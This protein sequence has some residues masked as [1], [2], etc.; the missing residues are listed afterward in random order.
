MRIHILEEGD[1][2]MKRVLTASLA[3]VLMMASLLLPSC[4]KSVFTMS[5]NT[6][7][8]MTIEAKNADKDAFFEVGSLVVADGEQ[9]SI[10]S[11]LEKGSVTVEI[12]AEPAEQSADELPDLNSE[13][14]LTSLAGV[15]DTT[16][17]GTVPAGDYMVKATVTEKATGTIDIDVTAAK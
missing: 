17:A 13:P 5:K 11:N 14:V 16:I 2:D 12:I 4:G 7:K 9:I 6:E 1:A 3:A 15:E 8:A 10:K